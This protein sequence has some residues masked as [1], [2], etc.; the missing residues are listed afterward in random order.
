M[1]TLAAMHDASPLLRQWSLLRAIAGDRES[2]VKSLAAATGMSEKTI[3]RDVSLLRCVGFPIEERSGDYGRKTFFL[4][5]PHTPALEFTYDEALALY[6]C[7][8]ASTGFG[9]TFVEQALAVA[10]RKIETSLG[11]RA[12]KYVDTMLARIVQ[13]Q[14]GGDYAGKAELLDRLFIAIEEDRAVFLTYQSQRS[15]EPV[16]YDVYPYRVIEHRGSLYLFGHSPDHGEP[17]TWKVDRITDVGLTDIHFQRPDDAQLNAQLSGNFG[18]FSGKGDIA[19]RIHFA[20]TAAR[21]VNEKRMHASQRVALQ[22]D[23]SALVEFQ[24]SSLVEIKSWILSFGPAAEVLEPEELREEI[25]ADLQALQ[26]MYRTGKKSMTSPRS[27]RTMPVVE[28]SLQG[29]TTIP[30]ARK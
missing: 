20:P 7:R 16:T 26:S 12:A 11:R 29:K 3:R 25:L 28:S 17:R 24:L 5:R 30:K 2:T 14:L 19:V 1:A 6:L 21:Y 22:P 13:T 9:G 23:G 10:F 15:T 27:R 8:R 4:N 18:I